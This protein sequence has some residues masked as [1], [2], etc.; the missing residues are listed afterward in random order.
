MLIYL[1]EKYTMQQQTAKC[2]VIFKKCK[3]YCPHN[4]TFHSRWL[5]TDLP[6]QS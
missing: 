3:D 1:Y 6:Y 4:A 5:V 2:N